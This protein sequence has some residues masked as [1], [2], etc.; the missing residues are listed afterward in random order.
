MMVFVPVATATALDL[1]AGQ[2]LGSARGFAV[3]PG[4]RRALGPATDDEEADFAALSAAG[5]GALDGLA[6]SRRLVLAAEVGDRQ[7]ADQQTELG[8]VEVHDLGWPQVQA[9][10][11]DEESAA[12]AVT[13]A[14]TAATGATLQAAFGLPAVVVLT[15]RYDLLW[16]APEELDGLR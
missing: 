3:T 8:E 15:D 13:A 9:L 1:R 7:V 12:T 14:A 4:L 11:A 10:F 6:G 2:P 5:V 16:Y